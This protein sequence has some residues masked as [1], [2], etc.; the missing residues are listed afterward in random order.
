MPAPDGSRTA[1]ERSVADVTYVSM[2]VTFGVPTTRVVIGPARTS[3]VHVNR[4]FAS[5]PSARSSPKSTSATTS[6]VPGVAGAVHAAANRTDVSDGARGA[7]AH[8]AT[9]VAGGGAGRGARL[10]AQPMDPGRGRGP[11][12]GDVPLGAALEAREGDRA[13]ALAAV[14]QSVR[15][16]VVEDEDI[17]APGGGV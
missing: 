14:R 6:Y 16:R 3:I 13:H 8:A 15:V 11:R 1:K 2:A 10:H 7:I 12:H 4:L 17:E 5:S 9:G